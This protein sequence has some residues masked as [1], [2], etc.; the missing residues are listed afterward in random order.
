MNRFKAAAQGRVVRVSYC[1]SLLQLLAPFLILTSGIH[2][3]HADGVTGTIA[4]GQTV[5]GTVTGK[6][7][8]SYTF[9][10]PVGDSF[11]VSV[12]ETG[13]HDANFV[14]QIELVPPGAESGIHTAHTLYARLEQ[15]NAAEGS[16][17]V[18]VSRADG[19]ST[20]G[21]Y[22]LTLIQV[23]GAL[24]GGVAATVMS[25]R[26]AYSGTNVRGDLQ[27]FTF[28]G[29]A[30]QTVTLTLTPTGGEGFGPEISIHAPDGGVSGF[31]CTTSCDHDVSLATSGLYTLVVSKS[32]QYDVTGTYTLSLGDKLSVNDQNSGEK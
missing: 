6:G 30:G 21:S 2:A 9:K 15:D 13:D 25:P 24:S 19:A 8:D 3:A 17:T 5:N 31:S 1:R 20:G 10:V 18:R 26:A 22:A 23:P 16:S 27:V 4:N 7:Y 12:S 14:P 29:V 28:S 32:D 11:V